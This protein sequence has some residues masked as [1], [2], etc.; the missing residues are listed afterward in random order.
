MLPSDTYTEYIAET[1]SEMF[2]DYRVITVFEKAAKVGFYIIPS[3][4][5]KLDDSKMIPIERI[6][7]ISDKLKELL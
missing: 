3:P 5:G 7:K 4:E 6:Q 1:M 2:P